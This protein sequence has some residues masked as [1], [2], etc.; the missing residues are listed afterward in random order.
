MNEGEV[1]SM[2]DLDMLHQDNKPTESRELIPKEAEMSDDEWIDYKLDK[3]DNAMQCSDADKGKILRWVV[4]NLREV[5][6]N[7]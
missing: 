6:K 3:Y 4:A 1:T 2:S 5:M 7:G